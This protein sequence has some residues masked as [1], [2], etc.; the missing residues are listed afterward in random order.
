[1]KKFDLFIGFFGNGATIYNKA[2]KEHGDYKKVAHI[3]ECGE[4]TWY[5]GHAEPGTVPGPALL[6]IEH[7]ADAMRANYEQSKRCA[8]T[9]F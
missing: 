6:R 4:I 8:H 9:Y 5:A 1:M 3:A 7:T 2:V